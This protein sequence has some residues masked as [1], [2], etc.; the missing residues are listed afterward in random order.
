[1]KKKALKKVNKILQKKMRSLIT[2]FKISNFQN[3]ISKRGIQK[4]RKE[5]R[6]HTTKQTLK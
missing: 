3:G 4:T 6:W 2:S 5:K 1:M